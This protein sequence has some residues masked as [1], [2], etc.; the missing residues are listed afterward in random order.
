MAYSGALTRTSGEEEP[1][2]LASLGPGERTEEPSGTEIRENCPHLAIVFCLCYFVVV[3]LSASS[4]F[5]LARPG[6]DQL[7]AIHSPDKS[8][9]LLWP[10]FGPTS[11]PRLL[12]VFA[13][14]TFVFVNSKWIRSVIPCFHLKT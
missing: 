7:N 3:F 13:Q 1:S 8:I 4:N 6:Y 2:D 10:L 14:L 9:K 11:P 5:P 12:Q